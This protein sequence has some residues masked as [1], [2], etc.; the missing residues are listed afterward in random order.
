MPVF[1]M[2]KLSAW[3]SW[4]LAADVPPI[5]PKQS[6]KKSLVQDA[7]RRRKARTN[8]QSSG[9]VL[10]SHSKTNKVFNLILKSNYAGSVGHITAA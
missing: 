8:E 2:D 6:S 3:E 1:K 7:L 9:F 4:A 5:Y 10:S